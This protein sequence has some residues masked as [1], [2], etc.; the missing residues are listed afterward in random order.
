MAGKTAWTRTFVSRR[1]GSEDVVID[2]LPG[3]VPEDLSFPARQIVA[4]PPRRGPAKLLPEGR[5]HDL[6]RPNNRLGQVG[7]VNLLHEEAPF[8]QPWGP[9]QQSITE[10]RSQSNR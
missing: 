10:M 3:Q 6:D 7:D 5:H 2:L 4:L 1:A 8:Q 9:C